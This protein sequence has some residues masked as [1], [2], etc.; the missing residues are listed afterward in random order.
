MLYEVGFSRTSCH[1]PTAQRGGGG[2]RREWVW[3]QGEEG[4]EMRRVVAKAVPAVLCWDTMR[5][6]EF[7]LSRLPAPSTLPPCASRSLHPLLSL[8]P[9][10]GLY[11]K[12][13]WAQL[14]SQLIRVQTKLLTVKF[15]I[16]FGKTRVNGSN[17]RH[18]LS[19]FCW[20]VYQV[21]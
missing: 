16:V 6:R 10:L 1:R 5:W 18:Q 20:K 19:W 8:Q 12:E 11:M 9:Q 4:R 13:A 14:E 15:D 21:V 17:W 2:G 7:H 3:S